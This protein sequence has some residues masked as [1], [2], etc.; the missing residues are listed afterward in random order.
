[1]TEDEDLKVREDAKRLGQLI[2]EYRGHLGWTQEDLA[3]AVYGSHESRTAVSKYENAHEKNIKPSTV[4]TYCREL[5]IP[6][7]QV[8]TRYLWPDAKGPMIDQNDL[9]TDIKEEGEK[10]SSEIRSRLDEMAKNSALNLNEILK[11]SIRYFALVATAAL[12]LMFLTS[13]TRVLASQQIGPR[14]FAEGKEVWSLGDCETSCPD[15]RSFANYL[16]QILIEE[17][18]VQG[19]VFGNCNNRVSR[20]LTKRRY[21]IVEYD[22]DLE[23]D[24]QRLEQLNLEGPFQVDTR[25][26]VLVYEE[27]S[28]VYPDCIKRACT[29]PNGHD[30]PDLVL[31]FKLHGALELCPL[32]SDAEDQEIICP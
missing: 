5:K 17:C 11:R 9:L 2:K 1:M 23:N 18:P 31:S 3:M 4:Q 15:G 13:Y 12:V 28:R 30:D 16:H 7:N 14:D 19:F 24:V 20:W 22:P 6:I 25:D 10:A 21:Q 32:R 8:P 27:L 26:P 29:D